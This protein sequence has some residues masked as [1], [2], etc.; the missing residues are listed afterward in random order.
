MITLKDKVIKLEETMV[1]QQST[2]GHLELILAEKETIN[3]LS[4]IRI[5]EKMKGVIYY[6]KYIP[7]VIN[8]MDDGEN[9][10]I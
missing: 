9:G 8:E 5:C 1:A 3:I 6:P 7:F 2:I 10:V 4:V